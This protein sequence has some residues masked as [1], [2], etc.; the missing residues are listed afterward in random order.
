MT[1][2]EKTIE[3]W[4]EIIVNRYHCPWETTAAKN[5]TV[6]EFRKN[7]LYLVHDVEEKFLNLFDA[8]DV[9]KYGENIQGK[10]KAHI[11][12]RTA[13]NT[14]VTGTAHRK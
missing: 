10:R 5:K 2:E 3:E 11:Q 7:S 14:R 12:L 4:Y 1:L 13:I 6:T 8:L 9:E